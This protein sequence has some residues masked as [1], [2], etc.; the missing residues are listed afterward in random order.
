MMSSIEGLRNILQNQRLIVKRKLSRTKAQL[1]RKSNFPY[2]NEAKVVKVIYQCLLYRRS[3]R[4]VI[5]VS[6]EFRWRQSD[7][8]A[9]QSDFNSN[10][11]LKD[12]NFMSVHEGRT[13]F[14]DRDYN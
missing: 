11:V 5:N 4:N 1:T 10:I 8:P 3:I 12:E 14:N 2:N 6:E 13:Y 9:S 7:R